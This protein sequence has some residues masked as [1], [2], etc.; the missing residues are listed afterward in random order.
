MWI[1]LHSWRRTKI[2]FKFTKIKG[3]EWILWWKNFKNDEDF[4]FIFFFIS[5]ENQCLNWELEK[6]LYILAIFRIVSTF[7]DIF[8][9]LVSWYF[10][11]ERLFFI[12]SRNGNSA[13]SFFSCYY[14]SSLEIAISTFFKSIFFFFKLSFIFFFFWCSSP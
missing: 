7:F 14:Y 8:I 5:I 10:Y 11:I 2:Q 9:T 6:L 4:I 12:I 1:R 13:D 3:I